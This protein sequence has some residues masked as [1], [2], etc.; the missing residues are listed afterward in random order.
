MFTG[1]GIDALA[2]VSSDQRGSPGNSRGGQTFRGRWHVLASGQQEGGARRARRRCGGGR[3]G[4]DPS[5][6]AGRHLGQLDERVRRRR[7]RR[8]HRRVPAVRGP[9]AGQPHAG[10][11]GAEH[12]LPDVR[13]PGPDAAYVPAELQPAVVGPAVRRLGAAGLPGPRALHRPPDVRAGPHLRQHREP[14]RRG[15]GCLP[16]R[17]AGPVPG[18]GSRGGLPRRLPVGVPGGLL[19][20]AGGRPA[21]MVAVLHDPQ[22][23]GRPDRSA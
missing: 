23:H 17:P 20:P 9:P 14:G 4:R 22:D 2:G 3:P 13:R 10:Q 19:R 7:G 15:Q 11:P 21:G 6:P 12:E 1:P 18:P 16:G 5:R 8:P